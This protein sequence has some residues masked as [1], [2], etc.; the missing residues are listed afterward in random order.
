MD[1]NQKPQPKTTQ[2]TIPVVIISG[3]LGAGKTSLI[4]GLLS[5][6]LGLKI[7]VIVNDFGKINLDALLVEQSTE[8]L[9]ALSNGCICCSLANELDDSLNLLANVKSKLD[10]ILIEASGVSNP[11][12][13]IELLRNSQN[14]FIKLLD[15]VYVIDGVN[16]KTLLAERPEL[17]HT[18]LA[19]AKLVILNKIDLIAPDEIILIESQIREANPQATIVKTTHARFEPQLLLDLPIV[20]QPK[21]GQL[22]QDHF[23]D[24]TSVSFRERQPLDPLAMTQLLNN[25][26]SG[27]YRLKGWMYFGK[28]SLHNRKIL[29]QKVGQT[30]QL[31]GA[32][33]ETKESPLTELVFIGTNFDGELLLNRLRTCIDRHPDDVREDNIIDSSKF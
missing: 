21:L 14:K 33:W 19:A 32:N 17:I 30:H 4:N 10:L 13:M 20:T 12:Q 8:E 6:A 18:H 29:I 24:F 3:H 22:S 31:T 11:L 27:V 1:R 7:G 5:N 16:F 23:A 15:L 9:I 25:L 2:T 26:P 28:K